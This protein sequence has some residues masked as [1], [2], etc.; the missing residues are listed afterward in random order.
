MVK[1]LLGGLYLLNLFN[2]REKHAVITFD[3]EDSV[4]EIEMTKLLDSCKGTTINSTKKYDPTQSNNFIGSAGYINNQKKINNQVGVDAS[5]R[6][7]S[8]K[9]RQNCIENHC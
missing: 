2:K 5:M 1:T 8:L 7:R 3:F 4:N 9:E 6:M